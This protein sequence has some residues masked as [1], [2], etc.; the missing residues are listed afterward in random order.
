MLS[1]CRA[2]KIRARV[3]RR[4]YLCDRSIH[5]GLVGNVEAEGATREVRAVRGG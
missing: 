3:T 5:A 4:V 2:S 1:I